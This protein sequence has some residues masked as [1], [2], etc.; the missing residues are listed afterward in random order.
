MTTPAVSIVRVGELATSRW[1]D[2]ARARLAKHTCVA[3]EIVECAIDTTFG[4]AVN[5]AAARAR[6]EHL[7]VMHADTLVGPDW[8]EPLLSTGSHRNAVVTPCIKGLDGAVVEAG[9]IARRN[10]DLVACG[11]GSTAHDL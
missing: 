5:R 4:A 7:V 8:L 10:G 1:N 11:R 3:H 2:V 6:G 9:L